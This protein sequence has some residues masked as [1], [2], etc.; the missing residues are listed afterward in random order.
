MKAPPIGTLA[1]GAV[2]VTAIALIIIGPPGARPTKLRD[3]TSETVP[4]ASSVSVAGFTLTSESIDL[5]FDEQQYPEGANADVINAN[6][7]SC[8]SA[9]MALTQPPL[10]K[11]KW[12]EIVIKMRDVYKAPVGEQSIP[13]IVDY[14]S[15]MPGQANSAEPGI[16]RSAQD[17]S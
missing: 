4:Q 8:H 12:R 7:T 6:C 14:L 17:K 16:E 11:D 10:S 1:F 2:G 9:S 5:P 3:P 13:A 15:T